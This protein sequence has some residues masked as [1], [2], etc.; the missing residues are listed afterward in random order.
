[1]TLLNLKQAEAANKQAE[2]ANEQA[3][4]ANKQAEAAVKQQNI[5]IF[6]TIATSLYVCPRGN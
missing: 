3:K 4:A 1:M 6:F 5:L 2:A